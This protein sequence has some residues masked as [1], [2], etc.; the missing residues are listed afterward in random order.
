MTMSPTKLL[1]IF[2][3]ASLAACSKPAPET[4]P[5]PRMVGARV[6][7]KL[8]A[9]IARNDCREATRRAIANPNIEVEKVAAPVAMKPLPVDT[10]KAPKGVTDRNGWYKVSF[11]VLVDTAG[12]ADMKTFVVDTA[13][14][15][16]LA[17]SVKSAVARWKFTPAEVAGC[18]IPRNYSLGISPK[19]KTPAATRPASRK[20]SK[21]GPA[22]PPAD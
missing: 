4:Q 8:E 14:H 9:P 5:E 22:K 13:S 15:P 6:N 18:K 1:A 11:H 7:D 19:N 21:S 16:W 3:A 12:K 20:A 2:A 10:R 17:T